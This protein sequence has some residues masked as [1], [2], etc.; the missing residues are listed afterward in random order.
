MNPSLQDCHWPD[1]PEPHLSALKQAVAF[2]L[3]SFDSVLG[4]IVCGSVSRG[5]FDASS[6]VDLYVVHAANVRQRIQK[7]FNG[8]PAEIFV[9][10]PARIEQ[11][12]AEDVRSRRLITTH[13]IGT[14]IVI[15]QGDAVVQTLRD[16]ARAL[17]QSSPS[18][19]A[20]LTSPRY[21]IATGFED[22]LD[23]LEK[24]PPTARLI[25]FKVVDRL[26]EFAFEKAG[27]FVPRQKDTLAEIRALD[28]MLGD[29]AERFYRAESLEAQFEIA[30]S[31]MD[32]LV[33]ARGF[34]EWASPLENL[35]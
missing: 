25:L 23:K 16:Q 20:D 27:R 31:M 2:V 22:A 11:Y 34:F 32:H 5:I 7:S 12:F 26:L 19:P 28:A 1:L 10:P 15:W 9:N 4:L 29:L 6:D 24:D 35:A 18:V 21:M 30:G 3:E 8:V 14:G 13:M 17:L 33:Q